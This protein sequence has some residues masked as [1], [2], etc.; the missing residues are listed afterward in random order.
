MRE[1]DDA[2][3]A[4]IAYVPWVSAFTVARRLGVRLT[5][6]DR[7]LVAHPPPV[8]A[9]YLAY[10]RLTA[11]LTALACGS[12]DE[13]VP[14]G[15]PDVDVDFDEA[16][17]PRQIERAYA[18]VA[19]TLRLPPAASL[20][21]YTLGDAAKAWAVLTTLSVRQFVAGRTGQ[22]PDGSPLVIARATLVG[23]MTGDAGMPG[24]VAEQVVDHLTFGRGMRGPNADP[25]IQPL[26]PVG[27]GALLIAPYLVL[28]NAFEQNFLRLTNLLN[29]RGR[30]YEALKNAKEGIL[31]TRIIE[32]LRSV[33][34]GRF[35]FNW[36]EL[37]FGNVDLAIR[38]ERTRSCLLVELKWLTNPTSALDVARRSAELRHGAGQVYALLRDAARG[39]DSEVRRKL[40]LG[41][42]YQIRGVVATSGWAGAVHTGV[43]AVDGRDQYL[44]TLNAHHLAARLRHATVPSVARWAYSGGHLPRAGRDFRASYVRHRFGDL[45][46]RWWRVELLGEMRQTSVGRDYTRRAPSE[47]LRLAHVTDWLAATARRLLQRPEL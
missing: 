38:D 32:E 5:V 41:R 43:E 22:V 3:R 34:P 31:R 28:F 8:S 25:V 35:S 47:V 26:I 40:G 24:T 29:P 6:E 20:G 30:A 42:G 12:A 15:G 4:A 44:P 39:G 37:S 14:A 10:N 33:R 17:L 27:H 18:S 23:I 19:A 36:A 46:L 7:T 9:Q 21:A 11:A 16:P 13:S 2:V 45:H 1:A